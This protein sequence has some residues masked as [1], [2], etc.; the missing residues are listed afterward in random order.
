MNTPE[1]GLTEVEA[2]ARLEQFGPNKLRE[3]E[4]HIWYDTR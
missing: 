4:R 2:A 3:K 1:E